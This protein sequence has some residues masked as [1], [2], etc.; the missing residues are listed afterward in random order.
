MPY[1]SL[2][3]MA[4]L[5]KAEHKKVIPKVPLT[6]FAV[7]YEKHVEGDKAAEVEDIDV[8]LHGHLNESGGKKQKR[9]FIQF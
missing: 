3:T 8:V 4:D 5:P 2:M 7:L 1:H 6:H 9:L